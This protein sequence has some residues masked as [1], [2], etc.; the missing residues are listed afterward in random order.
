[1]S[2][3]HCLILV[4]LLAALNSAHWGQ[5]QQ[6]S[7][8][9]AYQIVLRSRHSHATPDKSKSHRAQTGGGSITI[10]QPEPNTIVITMGGAAVVGSGHGG[11][12]AGIH[13]VLAQDMEIIPLR[14]AVR[15]PRIGMIGRV[16][17]TLH[18]SDPGGLSHSYGGADQGPATAALTVGGLD[19]LSLDVEPSS[20]ACGQD[21][22]INHQCGPVESP[23]FA[24]TPETGC[25]H[26]NASFSVSANQGKGVFCRQYAVADFDPAPQLD[27]F[28][29]DALKPF[30]AVPR[31]EFGFKL[32]VRVVEDLPPP[33]GTSEAGSGFV[34]PPLAS[35]YPSSARGAA[36]G[37]STFPAISRVGPLPMRTR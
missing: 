18:V 29:A 15:P 19:L 30:R 27:A 20:V 22:W 9:P 26:L 24:S 5:A 35:H 23:A 13:F 17:G 10:E 33:R 8:G 12:M 3:R 6:A 37:V 16:V 2:T 34:L 11:S 7:G 1:V 32:V 25:Y 14:S 21:L 4:G 36:I 28:W 31:S